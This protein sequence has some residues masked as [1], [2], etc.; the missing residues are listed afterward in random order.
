V[1]IDR[2]RDA[3]RRQPFEPFTIRMADGT[4]CHVRHPDFLLVPPVRRPREIAFLVVPEGGAEDEFHTHWLN[5][6]LIS[7]VVVPGMAELPAAPTED[8]GA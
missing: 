6:A 7:E 8:N 4:S 5:L 2:I 1:T 3:L